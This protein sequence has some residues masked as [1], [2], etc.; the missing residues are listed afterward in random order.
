[1]EEVN[2]IM[3]DLCRRRRVL[4]LRKRREV[5]WVYIELKREIR[6]SFLAEH[7]PVLLVHSRECVPVPEFHSKKRLK[8]TCCK[9]RPT[10]LCSL[11]VKRLPLRSIPEYILSI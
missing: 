10:P 11:S 1:M 9:V 2:F 5:V 6:S 7:G 8:L 3:R 4:I